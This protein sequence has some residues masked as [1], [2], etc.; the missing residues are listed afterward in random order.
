MV[1]YLIEKLS[2]GKF[3]LAHSFR[4]PQSMMIGKFM[5]LEEC[6]IVPSYH[7]G[8]GSKTYKPETRGLVLPSKACPQGTISPAK[9][10]CLKVLQ[11]PKTVLPAR[12][13][14]FRTSACRVKPHLKWTRHKAHSGQNKQKNHTTENRQ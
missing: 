9:P 5:G 14:T 7:N 3:V 12:E 10:Y 2:G 11:P 6:V 4:A 1:R 8:P 13:H